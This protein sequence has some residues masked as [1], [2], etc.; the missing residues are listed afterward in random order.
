MES[1]KQ[2]KKE[3]EKKKTCKK[4]SA[5]RRQEEVRETLSDVCA[6][7]GRQLIHEMVR[8]KEIEPWQ[9]GDF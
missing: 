7:E 9:T 6:P 2:E 3:N 1:L 8:N 5:L 4:I